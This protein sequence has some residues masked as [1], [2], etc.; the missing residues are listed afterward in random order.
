MCC[1]CLGLKG[2]LVRQL[3]NAGKKAEEEADDAKPRDKDKSK[4]DVL[5][6]R[7]LVQTICR[8]TVPLARCMD[9]MQEDLEN[10]NKEL[11]QW[12]HDKEETQVKLEEEI[13]FV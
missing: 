13:R 2:F 11:E 3:A 12:R 10:M 6:L 8:N 9:Y 7:E 5:R 1:S 4:D